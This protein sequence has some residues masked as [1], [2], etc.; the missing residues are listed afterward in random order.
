MFAKRVTHIWLTKK[1][2]RLS[3]IIIAFDLQDFPSHRIS[4][5]S[6]PHVFSFAG[7]TGNKA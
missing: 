1:T 6:V 5:Q 7:G 3:S 4:L 2:K